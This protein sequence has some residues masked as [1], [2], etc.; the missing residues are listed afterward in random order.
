MV[1]IEKNDTVL[2]QLFS[3][4]ISMAATGLADETF[5]SSLISFR[6]ELSTA[7]NSVATDQDGV[8]PPALSILGGGFC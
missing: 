5:F 4:K 7:V 3:V 6:S 8:V 2:D 1:S